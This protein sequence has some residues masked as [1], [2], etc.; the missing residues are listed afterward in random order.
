MSEP[1]YQCTGCGKQFERRKF[2]CPYCSTPGI[3]RLYKYVPYN[4]HSLSILINKKA[5]FSPVNQFSDPFEFRFALEENHHNGIPINIG[6]VDNARQDSMK[7]GVFC[8][9]EANDNILMWSHYADGHRGFCIEF[10]RSESNELGGES[11][12]PVIYPKD[13]AVPNFK[14]KALAERKAFA[15][16]ATTKAKLWVYEKE[17]RMISRDPGGGLYPIPGRISAII[18][19]LRMVAQGKTTIW[20][21]LGEDTLYFQAHQTDDSYTLNIQRF[22]FESYLGKSAEKDT[23]G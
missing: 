21:I 12:V 22:E 20:N 6:S 14:L 19:G 18:F 7:L 8:L 10:E 9:T 3:T 16:I 1:T 13:N 15:R 17:W 11:C 2:K 23:A 4:E 5:W